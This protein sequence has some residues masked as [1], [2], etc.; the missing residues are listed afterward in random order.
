MKLII[1]AFFLSLLCIAC[2][3][4]EPNPDAYPMHD[5][6]PSK[7][8]PNQTI[9]DTIFAITIAFDNEGTAWIGT[10]NQGLVKY[11]LTQTK[12]FD[13]INSP[14]MN[15]AIWDIEVDSKNNVW[16]G[17]NGLVKYDGEDFTLYNTSNSKIP[18]DIVWSIAIDSND[19]VWVASSRHREG[20]IARFDGN[21]FEVYTP[22]NSPLPANGAHCIAI[23]RKDNIWVAITEYVNS[24]YLVKISGKSWTVFDSIDFE[25]E[26]YWV[27][28][29]DI[30]SQGQVF[31]VIDYSL[32]SAWFNTPHV[33][34][35]DGVETEVM[36]FDNLP[37]GF[38][39]IM[40]D[41]N[42]NLWCTYDIGFAYYNG[43]EWVRT[44]TEIQGKNSI[45]T[46]EQSRDGNIWIGKGEG[47]EIRS[48]SY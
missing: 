26:L 29:I 5:P 14:I 21:G 25:R 11:G 41:H 43:D 35:F 47:I 22:D 34:S 10:L 27:R 45:F 37:R 20:G 32:S 40:I 31:G 15:T 1:F 12:I 6:D 16:I 24:T 3:I 38:R 33:F 17:T 44:D 30:N 4:A 46:I 8:Y 39:T 28:N 23:D 7:F 36:E 2:E 19:D 48:G 42:D 13:S 9:L 18:E